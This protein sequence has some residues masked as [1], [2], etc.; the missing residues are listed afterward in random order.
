[1]STGTG[2]TAVSTRAVI[3]DLGDADDLDDLH[4]MAQGTAGRPDNLVC[5]VDERAGIDPGADASCRGLAEVIPV[6]VLRHRGGLGTFEDCRGELHPALTAAVRGA[7]R[8]LVER[9]APG[10]HEVVVR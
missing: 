1:M 10:Y 5:L 7:V 2:E 3:L 8:A 4:A 9:R 6:A